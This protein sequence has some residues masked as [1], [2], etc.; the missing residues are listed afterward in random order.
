MDCCC[1]DLLVLLCNSF[2]PGLVAPIRDVAEQLAGAAAELRAVCNG[3]PPGR[4][5]AAFRWHTPAGVPRVQAPPHRTYVNGA[6][7]VVS[8]REQDL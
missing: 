1:I 4:A 3:A 5:A 2:W 7:L 6:T 8:E